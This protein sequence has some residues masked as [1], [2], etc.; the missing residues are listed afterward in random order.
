M[1]RTLY[2]LYPAISLTGVAEGHRPIGYFIQSH[3]GHPTRK[4]LTAFRDGSFWRIRRQL[5][6]LKSIACSSSLRKRY[7]LS[8]FLQSRA[9]HSTTKLYP[10]FVMAR[11]GTPR[12]FLTQDTTTFYSRLALNQPFMRSTLFEF[13]MPIAST[14]LSLLRVWCPEFFFR[15]T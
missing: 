2:S 8:T 3:A 10:Q 11:P 13:H 9:D 14:T 6:T 7:A 15:A 1:P 12:T 4:L 5:L